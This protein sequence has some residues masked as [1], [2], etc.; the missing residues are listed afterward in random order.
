MGRFLATV[1]VVLALLVAY[2]TLLVALC[3]RYTLSAAMRFACMSGYLDMWPPK[4]H[5]PH[6]VATLWKREFQTLLF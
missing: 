4:S 5:I 3:C 1:L 2:A 6:I